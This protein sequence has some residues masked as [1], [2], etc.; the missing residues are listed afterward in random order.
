[1]SF[2]LAIRREPSWSFYNRTPEA[3]RFTAK[4]FQAMR[5][6][7]RGELEPLRTLIH[8]SA[9]VMIE[10]SLLDAKDHDRRQ[11]RLAAPDRDRR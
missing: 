4:Y 7:H 5:K 2:S 8:E 10:L 1:M 11:E 9:A 3:S 6:A